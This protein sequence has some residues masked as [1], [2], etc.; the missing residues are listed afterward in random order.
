MDS[1]MVSPYSFEFSL[2]YEFF[3]GS[4]LFLT[5]VHTPTNELF[6]ILPRISTPL[7]IRRKFDELIMVIEYFYKSLRIKITKSWGLLMNPNLMGSKPPIA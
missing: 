3:H 1:F 2:K 5:M 4:L 7:L 6:G